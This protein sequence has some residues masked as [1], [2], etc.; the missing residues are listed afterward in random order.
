VFVTPASTGVEER[1]NSITRY[2]PQDGDRVRIVFGPEETE[3]VVADDRTI[4][5][6]SQAT[7]DA[8][9]IVTDDG[10]D[11]GTRFDPARIAVDAGETVK[12]V[13]K[14]TGAISHGFR[15]KGQEPST[16]RK[17]TCR[18]PDGEARRQNRNPQPGAQ[19]LSSSKMDTR[20]RLSS[21][22]HVAGQGRRDRRGT[23]RRRRRLRRRQQVRLWMSSWTCDEGQLL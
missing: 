23:R 15:V 8:E 3:P 4:I 11:P 7:R 17:M 19:G 10:T 22:R 2:G 18:N 9:I 21:G 1:I 20:V 13:V 16:Q 5:P 14:N 12:V 6:E